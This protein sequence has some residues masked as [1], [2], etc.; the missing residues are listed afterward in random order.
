VSTATARHLAS[1]ELRS[2]TALR[3]IAALMVVFSHCIRLGEVSYAGEPAGV[4]WPLNYIDFG[5]FGVALFFT[6]SGY[7]LY[8]SQHARSFDAF[9]YFTRRVFRVYPVFL[10][11][12]PVYIVLAKWIGKHVGFGDSGYISEFDHAVSANI[13][14]QYLTFTFNFG[15]NFGYINNI[16]WTLPVEFQFYL[17]FPVFLMIIR[18]SPLA[19]IA[20]SLLLLLAGDFIEIQFVT[21]KLAWQFALG[22]I[23]AMLAQTTIGR[24]SDATKGFATLFA[25]A[26]VIFTRELPAHLPVIPGF[27]TQ[28]TGRVEGIYYGVSATIIVFCATAI[29]P[30]FHKYRLTDILTFSGRISYSVYIWHNCILLACYTMIVRSGLYGTSR[31]LAIYGVGIPIILMCS[32]VSYFSIEKPGINA[33][34]SIIDWRRLQK[35]ARSKPTIGSLTEG[36][37]D[38]PRSLGNPP[39]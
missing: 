32:Y 19:L 13:L 1:D 22:M 4:V 9:S 16:Y 5:V 35:F 14:L 7:T 39:R 23:A 33:G 18:I 37:G 11:S 2:L 6:L 25:L 3:G 34:K 36:E 12:V 31:S 30:Y 20:F 24:L 26:L 21:F 8:L 27:W 17:L 10:V 28:Y 15:E 29:E 38:H